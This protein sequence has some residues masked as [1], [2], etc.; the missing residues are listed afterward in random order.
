MKNN[1]LVIIFLTFLF[2]QLHAEDLNIQSSTIT[3]D[4]KTK[5]TIFKDDVVATDIKNNVF[6]SNYAE[7]DKKLNLLVSKGKTTVLTSEG[8][9][10]TG[11]DI[12]FDNKNKIIKSDQPG[13]LTDLEKNEIYLD[14]FEYSIENNFFKSSGKIKIIDTNQNSYHFSQV[15]IDEKKKE[16]IGTDIKSFLNDASF[17]INKKNK[18]RIFA[19]TVKIGDEKS[20][21]TKSVFT[22]CDYRES[23]K[24]PPWALQ[25]SKMSHDKKKKTIYYDNALIKFYDFPIFYLPKL[26]H[27][28]P[29]VDRRSGFLP[30]SFSDSKN[31][32]S[33]FEIPYFWAVN[34]DKD[35]TISNKLYVSENP[36][37]LG[38]Y[39]QVFENSNLIFDFG[40]TEGY[41]KTSS[42]KKAGD[43]S[44][45]FTK[46]VKNFK[47]SN[48]SENTL[49]LTTQEVSNDK[50]L[51][52]YKIKSNL[53]DHQ[54][55]TLENS[56]KFTH[57]NEDLF[58]GF[59]ATSHETLKEDY[60]DKYEYILPDIILDKN[61]FADSKYG[62]ADLTS[63]LKIH[64][65]DT[66]KFTKF[67]VNDIDWKS[68]NFDYASGFSGKLLGNIKN[69]NYE[70]K[71]TQYKK[72][73]T[74]ELFGAL[75]YL[76]EIELFKNSEEGFNQFLTP[77]FL[78]RYAPGHMRKQTADD[79]TRLDH[80]NVFSLDRLNSYNNYESGLSA[81][82]GF[83]YQAKSKNQQ[84]DFTV[85]QVVN[86]RE[87]KDMPTSSSLDEKLS[88]LVATTN[89]KINENIKFKY[90]FALDQSYKQ[91]NYNEIG[92]TLDFNKV[93]FN[94]NYL[95]EIEHIGNQEYFNTKIDLMNS[96]KGIFSAETKRNLIT[97]SA[98]YYNLSYE[99]LNDCLRA[100][101]VYRREFYDDSELEAENSLMF[102]ITLI[103][104]GNINTPSFNQ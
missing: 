95:Q 99:Y 30:P 69:V 86:E 43:K 26:S 4:K 13:T 63:N 16:I 17:K 103:P 80:L 92:T 7:Y 1:F 39:R 58:F 41:K 104:F 55:D 19:N 5:I 22:L 73:T 77:K 3:I 66:N 6:S 40:Y 8:F 83:D 23:D 14:K 85:G 34:K 28:D 100:G 93:K 72:D 79:G 54:T 97:N 56:I 64:N 70:A 42:T 59:N 35:F 50:Y 49:E 74:N 20:E 33:G 71:N 62:A 81:T 89:L 57:T 101:I 38:E 11:K 61:L 94:F 84:L 91:L 18:P 48:N 24:C 102:N 76:S 82:L 46:F 31:L 15:Y 45:Y 32:G 65:Y 44:H 37:F 27:P 12:V 96:D 51:K 47:S 78:I 9:F 52:L 88:D 25:A 68:K 29:T 10:L 53:V 98:E 67:L 2:Q 75:G 36:L 21:F 90:D 60:N 87:N